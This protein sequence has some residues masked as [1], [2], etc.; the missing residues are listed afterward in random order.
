VQQTT[1]TKLPESD[2]IRKYCSFDGDADRIVYYY[3]DE[4]KQF[5]LLDGDKIATL[6]SL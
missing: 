1:P 4:E 6:V 2:S 5:H 3:L